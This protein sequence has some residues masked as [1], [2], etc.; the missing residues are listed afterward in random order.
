MKIT[1]NIPAEFESDYNTDRF[2]DIF[3]R[4]LAD[5]HN[6]SLLCGNYEKETIEMLKN[7]FKQSTYNK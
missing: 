4:I 2:E 7:A 6:N 1:I 5:L 3:N